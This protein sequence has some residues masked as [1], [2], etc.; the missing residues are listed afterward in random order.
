MFVISFISIDYSFISEF[1]R[2]YNDDND[3]PNEI[4]NL[5]L[6]LSRSHARIALFDNYLESWS[7]NKYVAMRSANVTSVLDLRLNPSK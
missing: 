6:S 3:R 1:F 7:A 4:V 2:Q 5:S